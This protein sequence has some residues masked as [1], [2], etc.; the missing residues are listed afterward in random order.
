[1]VSVV[2]HNLAT[3][4]SV[5][6]KYLPSLAR[7]VKEDEASEKVGGDNAAVQAETRTGT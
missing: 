7:F 6:S 5:E 1:M 2:V 4:G 3:R